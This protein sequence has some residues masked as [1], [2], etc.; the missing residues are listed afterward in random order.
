MIPLVERVI[1]AKRRTI[2]NYPCHVNRASSIGHPCERFL[3]Y[4]RANW[5]DRALIDVGLKFIFDIGNRIE[6]EAVDELKAAG[7]MILEQQRPFSWP[8]FNITGHLDF[9]V[10]EK[11]ADVAIP[12]EVKGLQHH[13][14][15]KLHTVEDFFNS[16]KHYVRGYPAQLQLY[17][18]MSNSPEGYFYLKSKM[19][20]MP[21]AVEVVLDFEYTEG[22]VQKVER[23]NKAIEA[24]APPERMEYDPAV[25]G[26]CAFAH[27]CLPSQDFGKGAEILDNEEMEGWLKRRAELEPLKKEF[28]GLD[29]LIKSILKER[30]NLIIGNFWIKGRWKERKGYAVKDTK[31]WEI[32][33]LPLEKK[34]E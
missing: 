6:E 18:L 15:E 26:S 23:V 27:I 2:K 5:Q 29:E 7:F 31:Y 11:G 22:I 13:E 14:W 12:V 28:D 30:E 24:G 8:K 17:L 3:Y 1:E 25:C 21:K 33:I 34:A 10:A 20:G 32:K 9:K 16:K 4:C 19:N